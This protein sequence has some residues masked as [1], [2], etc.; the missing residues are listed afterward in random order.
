MSW[1]SIHSCTGGRYCPQQA[2]QECCTPAVLRLVSKPRGRAGQVRHRAQGLQA[3]PLRR[4]PKGR[5]HPLDLCWLGAHQGNAAQRARWLRQGKHLADLW[6]GDAAPGRSRVRAT[7]LVDRT[8][9][10]VNS[11]AGT[12]KRGACRGWGGGRWRQRQRCRIRVEQRVVRCRVGLGLWAACWQIVH[13]LEEHPQ[14]NSCSERRPCWWGSSIWR[15]RWGWRISRGF[16]QCRGR[17]GV[18]QLSLWSAHLT[19]AR[20]CCKRFLRTFGKDLGK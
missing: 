20:E 6:G 4:P 16:W 15:I 8:A 19:I 5:G 11:R 2:V 3:G 10:N 12:R 1:Q 7:G 9:T 17:R 18:G 13:A 14:K